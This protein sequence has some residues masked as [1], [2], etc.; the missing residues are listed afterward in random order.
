MRQICT[1]THQAAYVEL[2]LDFLNGQCSH[3]EGATLATELFKVAKGLPEGQLNLLSQ[4]DL[5]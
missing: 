3:L 1:D 2:L 4:F 5:F